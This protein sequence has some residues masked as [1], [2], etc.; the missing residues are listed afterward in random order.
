MMLIL[1]VVLSL[2]SLGITECMCL[3]IEYDIHKN[4][5]FVGHEKFRIKR[6]TT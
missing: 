2:I 1:A 5:H 4:S 6:R 3:G